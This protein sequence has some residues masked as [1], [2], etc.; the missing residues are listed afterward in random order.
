MSSAIPVPSGSRFDNV[1][2]ALAILSC[3]AIAVT[4][5]LDWRAVRQGTRENQQTRRILEATEQVLSAA[6]DAETG[7]RGYL[8]T[9]NES[10]LDPYNTAKSQI[11]ALLGDL[12]DA[13][14][15]KREQAARAAEIEKLMREKFAELAET[16]RLDRKDGHA[17]AVA[18]VR[19]NT[20]KI[21]MDRIRSLAGA[22]SS[23]E[24]RSLVSRSE[25]LQRTTELTRIVIMTGSLVLAC[26]LLGAERAVTQAFARRDQAIRELDGSRKFLETTLMGIGD[27]VICTDARGHVTLINPVAQALTEWSHKAA[28]GQPLENVFRIVEETSHRPVESPVAKVLR[29]GTVVGLANHTV[30]ITRSGAEVPIDDSG[31]PIRDPSGQIAGVVLVFRNI[32]E[33]RNAERAVMDSEQRFRTL[34][35]ALPEL[36]WSWQSS[37]ELEYVNSLARSFAGWKAGQSVCEEGWFEL[38]HPEEQQTYRER[39][40]ESVKN[41][42]AFEMQCRL[43]RAADGIYRWFL[44]RAVPVSDG[45]GAPVRWITT[46][47]EI[48][49]QMEAAARVRAANEALQ[50]SNADLEQFAYAASHDLREPLRM[51]AVYSQLLQQE[52]RDR[53]DSQAQSYIAF[54]VNGARRME[55]LLKDL[56]FYSRV[57]SASESDET[58]DSNAVLRVALLNLETAISESVAEIDASDLPMVAVPEPHLIQLF[59]NLIANAIKYRGTAAP[60]VRILAE[61]DDGRWRFSI[62][63]NGIGI[64]AQYLTQIFGVFK[65][66]HGPEYEGTGIGLA[67]C[68]RIVERNGGRIWVESERGKGSTFFFTLKAADGPP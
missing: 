42:A 1:L 13:T 47:T 21:A 30:L 58:V 38:I 8:L 14:S 56:L 61:R 17:A 3:L 24:L 29:E 37:G 35:S 32:T 43:R 4:T 10:Y 19:S 46:C 54:A 68:Q 62:A 41:G 36:V 39:W 28:D 9:G 63:N 49:H 40:A 15:A 59:Q 57:S 45:T 26:L 2:R 48:H 60:Y 22:I 66:L 11:N 67:M 16:I 33:R 53:L 23:D 64:D 65:R 52:Y 12:S 51:V 20:G 44:C 31:A 25:Q 50:R 5:Y 27:A 34:P 18:L 55:A 7:Q 6:K